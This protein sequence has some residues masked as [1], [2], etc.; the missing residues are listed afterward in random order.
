M[1]SSEL[2][3]RQLLWEG[4]AWLTNS[5]EEW[6]KDLRSAS[7]SENVEIERKH[8]VSIMLCYT[9]TRDKY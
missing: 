6:P 9:A 4:P 3:E 2:K 8:R 1:S 7:L 5:E